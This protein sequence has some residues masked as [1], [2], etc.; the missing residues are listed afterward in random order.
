M[1]V[2]LVGRFARTSRV[3]LLV[4]GEIGSTQAASRESRQKTALDT[5][6][7]TEYLGNTRIKKTALPV[8]TNPPRGKFGV[9][10]RIGLI[11]ARACINSRRSCG[12]PGSRHQLRY[13]GLGV[14]GCVERD[15]TMD[16]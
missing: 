15:R 7:S 10:G 11:S 3:R 6:C 5:E 8:P 4:K 1:S 12:C 16:I 13:F 2:A 9:N 14:N